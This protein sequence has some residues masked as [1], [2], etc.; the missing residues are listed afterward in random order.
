M[1]VTPILGS[2]PDISLKYKNGH[3]QKSGQKNC[4]FLF[5]RCLLCTVR[6]QTYQHLHQVFKIVLDILLGFGLERLEQWVAQ[7]DG[8]ISCHCH[9]N[10]CSRVRVF[11]RVQRYFFPVESIFAVK[12]ERGRD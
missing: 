10:I 6:G 3:N 12:R 8:T 2:S 1:S 5:Q 4:L 9:Y 11:T 7:L